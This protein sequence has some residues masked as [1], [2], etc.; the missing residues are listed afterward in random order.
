MVIKS[1]KAIAMIELIFALVIMGIVLMSAPML[2]QQSVKSS[3]V[4]L[5]QEAI[6][7]TAS[8]TS[9]VLSMYWDEED[10]FQEEN[11]TG[12]TNG[13]ILD[14]NRSGFTF[15]NNSQSRVKPLRLPSVSII[16]P[17]IN[18]S[19]TNDANETN[20]FEFDDVDDFN[21]ETFGLV[22]FNDEESSSDIGDYVDNNISIT[23][24]VNFVEDMPVSGLAINTSDVNFTV[25]TV[26]TNIKL[27][28]VNLISNQNVDELNKNITLQAF[29]CNIGSYSIEGNETL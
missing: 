7:A 24:T 12:T 16:V 27:I 29:S 19:S 13:D 22:I 14:I 1:K 23:T 17:T 26:P 4:G 8:H 9:M 18:T 10:S 2:I 25:M 28:T 3:N 21:G 11:T 20:Y 5:Q 6:T 15:P